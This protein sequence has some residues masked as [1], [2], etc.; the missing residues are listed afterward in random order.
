MP[1]EEDYSLITSGGAVV[2]V[3]PL[4][5]YRRTDGG[6]GVSQ[7]VLNKGTQQVHHGICSKPQL[8]AHFFKQTD[9]I[10]KIST[11]KQV[12]VYNVVLTGEVTINSPNIT[13]IL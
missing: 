9:I 10:R 1:D 13:S 5:A 8:S 2:T 7:S 6:S 11:R 4:Q 3:Q 12:R